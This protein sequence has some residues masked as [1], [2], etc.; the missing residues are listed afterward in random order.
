LSHFSK[1][2]GTKV[3]S[4]EAFIKAC[5]EFGMTKVKRDVDI[6]PWARGDASEHVEVFCGYPSSQYGIGLKKSEE[7]GYE[8][9]S[10]WSLTGFELPE[11]I[12]AKIP[13]A[14]QFP[15][16]DRERSIEG[17]GVARAACDE[18]RG[19]A[20]QTVAKHTIKQ[21]Y[22]SQGFMVS[23]VEQKDGSIKLNLT[24]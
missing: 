11:E 21:V 7:S 23:E 13:H 4:V 3:T 5:A 19:L 10:D 6:R 2:K 22:S 18:F 17:H 8:M 9:V 20:M 24:R 16:E 12:Q 15:G 1:V 14:H